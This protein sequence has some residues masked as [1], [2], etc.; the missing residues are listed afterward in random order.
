MIGMKETKERRI[1]S[2]SY[3]GFHAC[4]LFKRRNELFWEVISQ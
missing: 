2:V 3:I 1:F 4:P